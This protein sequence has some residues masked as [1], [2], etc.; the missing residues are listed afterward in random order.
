LVFAIL[1]PLVRRRLDRTGAA[2]HD[3][4]FWKRT[5]CW[6][7]VFVDLPVMPPSRWRLDQWIARPSFSTYL[8]MPAKG[9]LADIARIRHRKRY[10]CSDV[11]PHDANK[12]CAH[13]FVGIT[14]GVI[15]KM[16][17]IYRHDQGEFSVII[18]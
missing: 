14:V 18:L 4:H 16:H 9:A 3:I 8:S 2:H 12:A 10:A 7:N 11:G 1:T 15:L 6:S 5:R 17:V 13:M